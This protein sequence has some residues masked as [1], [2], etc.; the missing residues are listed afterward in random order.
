ML[1]FLALNMGSAEA[2]DLGP[3]AR[4]VLR[5]GE[6]TSLDF[7]HPATGLFLAARAG[8]EDPRTATTLT[9]TAAPTQG[10]AAE[11]VIVHK[12]GAPASRGRDEAT[13]ASLQLD[14]L[15]PRQLRARLVMP[16][17]DVFVFA[18]LL[19]EP[20]LDAL[21]NHGTLTVSL[22]EVGRASFSLDGFESAWTTAWEA[23]QAFLAP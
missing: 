21:K 16:R 3:W 8:T 20:P 13:T 7:R 2:V 14:G 17:G 5:H 1:P 22:S 12:A 23:C 11:A 15:P 4:H 19:D 6:W 18:Q 9:L 10:C